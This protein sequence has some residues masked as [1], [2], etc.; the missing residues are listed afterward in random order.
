MKKQFK[1]MALLLTI[2]MLFS[3]SSCLATKSTDSTPDDTV[4]K[5]GSTTVEKDPVIAAPDVIDIFYQ[6]A[7]QNFPEGFSHKDNWLMNTICEMANVTLGE[8]I[9][10]AYTDTATKFNIM[11]A[12]GNIPDYV[13]RADVNTMKQYGQ[14]GAFL[15]LEDIIGNSPIL[16]NKYNDL[17]L[18]TL[19]SA[20]GITYILRSLPAE[21][22]ITSMLIRYDLLV[23]LGFDIPRTLDDYV[24]IFRAIKK[25]YPDSVPYST[26]DMGLSGT[27][28]FLFTPFN[29]NHSGWA[30]YPERNKVCNVFEG[31]NIVKAVKF[32]KSL[33]DE[34]LFDKEFVT[35]T[36][37][38]W[39]IK[40]RTRQ[41]FCYP[42]NRGTLAIFMQRFIADGN[43]KAMVVPAPFP[44]AEGVGIDEVYAVPPLIGG[45]CCAI[46]AKTKKQDAVV[47]FIETLFSDEIANGLSLYGRE[48]IEY[49]IIDG[50]KIPLFPAAFEGGWA[51]VYGWTQSNTKEKL[52]YKEKL[53][54]YSTE[55]SEESK[56][57]YSK[58]LAEC[59][60]LVHK[61]M[62]GK[63]DYSPTNFTRPL[64]DEIINRSSEAAELQKSIVTKAIVGEMSIEEFI[65]QKE[66]IVE[67]Y[68]DVTKAHNDAIDEIR[69]KLGI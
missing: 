19:K 26:R 37:D 32:A 13:H 22:D 49:N 53:Y 17:Q 8:V 27:G 33:Y 36:A 69:D 64:P 5:D 57:E 9:V 40:Q 4:Q 12:S 38:D 28:A 59:T 51:S 54:I 44:V 18:E 50:E 39:G 25:K 48:G 47:R 34:G 58:I 16:S 30:W 3:L 21:D 31:D 24:E 55:E 65:E 66:K 20:D 35:I 52:A 1:T 60:D 42:N 63:L 45:H 61:V 14:E 56:K 67:K 2:I 62:K 6:E 46:S 11:M 7:N 68:K 43:T 29:T 41:V 15:P 10:P 23:E